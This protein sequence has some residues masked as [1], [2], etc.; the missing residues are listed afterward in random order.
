MRTRR[1]ERTQEKAV[2]GQEDQVLVM[3]KDW[4]HRS[5]LSK[6]YRNGARNF[7]STVRAKKGGTTDSIICPCSK[8]TNVQF[9]HFEIVYEHLLIKGMDPAYT[10]TT[11]IHHGEHPNESV[12]RENASAAMENQMFLGRINFQEENVPKETCKRRMVDDTDLLSNASHRHKMIRATMQPT[13]RPSFAV[14]SHSVHEEI[15]D[16]DEQSNSLDNSITD[17]DNSDSSNADESKLKKKRGP[18]RMGLPPLGEAGRMRVDFNDRGQV[19]SRNSAKLSSYAGVIARDN[20]PVVIKNWSNVDAQKKD[21]LW[22]LILERFIIDTS[23]KGRVL[24]MIGRCWRQFKAKLTKDIMEASKKK[25]KAKA[26]AHVRPANIKSDLEWNEFVEERLSPGFQEKSEKYRAIRKKLKFAHTMSRKGYAR[27]EQEMKKTQANPSTI[28][29]VDLW[30]QGHLKRNG[31]PL[32]DEIASI[33]EELQR[34]HQTNPDTPLTDINDDA[35][36]KILGPEGRG[37]VRGL[38]LGAS[39]SQVNARL[40]YEERIKELEDKVRSQSSLMEAQSERIEKLE[41][42]VEKIVDSMINKSQ[43]NHRAIVNPVMS[44]YAFASQCQQDTAV[45]NCALKNARCQLL[46]WYM[47][48]TEDVEIVAEGRIES[49]DYKAKVKQVPLGRDCWKV[50]IEK[51]INPDVI[52]YRPID[53]RRRFLKDNVGESV[54]WAVS[55]IRLML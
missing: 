33:V 32:N 2:E 9:Q 41:K 51:I 18:T 27:L 44:S 4:V 52:M 25:N 48:D 54:A 13:W 38:G 42:D 20:V 3:D 28:S 23:L 8:C 40:L 17:E 55:S 45:S 24:Q 53:S 30:T 39:R 7:V 12:F 36:A 34:Q 35:L 19:I 16:S 10:N 15:M 6:E 26:I 5:R 47:F 50:R 21:Q 14:S 49:T 29:R 46:H 11:W 37:Q 43:Q 1:S 22:N 31:E